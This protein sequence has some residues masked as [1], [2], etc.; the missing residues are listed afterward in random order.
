MAKVGESNYPF[1]QIVSACCLPLWH[2][3]NFHSIPSVPTSCSSLWCPYLS[4]GRYHGF[5]CSIQ[6]NTLHS[7]DSNPIGSTNWYVRNNVNEVLG[8]DLRF[9]LLDHPLNKQCLKLAHTW[10]TKRSI[11]E[12]QRAGPGGRACDREL[13]F[14]NGVVKGYVILPW[15]TLAALAVL[16]AIPVWWLVEMEG[17]GGCETSDSEDDDDKGVQ[18]EALLTEVEEV[19]RSNITRIEMESSSWWQQ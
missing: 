15:W 1:S 11:H 10:H 2:M 12:Y 13:T 6:F 7:T 4:Q 17:F 9:P 16:G 8:R 19:Q 18:E 14:S 3:W 5:P